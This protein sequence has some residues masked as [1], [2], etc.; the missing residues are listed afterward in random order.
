MHGPPSPL[1]LP[2][3]VLELPTLKILPET[4]FFG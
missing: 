3:R 1:S 4:V 2:Q